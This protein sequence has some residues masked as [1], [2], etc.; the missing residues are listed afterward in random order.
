MEPKVLETLTKESEELKNKVLYE[1]N[2]NVPKD[3]KHFFSDTAE[4]F[5][6]EIL[7]NWRLQKRYDELIEYI[8]YQYDTGGGEEFWKQVLL[9]LRAIEKD[10]KRA[11]RLLQGLLPGRIAMH[12]ATLKKMKQY[13]DNY[14]LDIGLAKCVGEIMSVY[15]EIV[16][17]LENKPEEF[18]NQKEIAKVKKEIKKILLPSPHCGH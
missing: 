1:L 18:K 7:A 3:I 11:L 4:Y 17:I 8:H 10:E 12:K 15:F 6:D 9:D 14:I 13:P 2:N 16:F 5:R